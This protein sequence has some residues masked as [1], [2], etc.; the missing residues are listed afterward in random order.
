MHY[1]KYQKMSFFYK[2]PWAL[3]VEMK[4]IDIIISKNQALQI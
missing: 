4:Q 1:I 2:N 3:G